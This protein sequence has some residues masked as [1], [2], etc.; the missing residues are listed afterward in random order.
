MGGQNSCS[1]TRSRHATALCLANDIEVVKM[2]PIMK[3]GLVFDG[4][5]GRHEV[6]ISLLL[7]CRCYSRPNEV[8]SR[9]ATDNSFRTADR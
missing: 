4:S 8:E 5:K 6:R 9:A 1:T 3:S 7:A 2:Q